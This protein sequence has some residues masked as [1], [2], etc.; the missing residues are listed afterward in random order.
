MFLQC[1]SP[2]K[3]SEDVRF[4]LLTGLTKISEIEVLSAP[5]KNVDA[6]EISVVVN[7]Y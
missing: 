5:I 2:S 3:R 1:I 4:L 6:L 7:S